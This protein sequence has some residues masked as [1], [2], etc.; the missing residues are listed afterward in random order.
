MEHAT[1][2]PARFRMIFIVRFL[3]RRADQGLPLMHSDVFT[4]TRLPP[5]LLKI[6]GGSNFGRIDFEAL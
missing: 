5:W 1:D 6:V 3:V 2:M 4:D